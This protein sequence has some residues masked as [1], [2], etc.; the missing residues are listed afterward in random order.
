MCY[1][2]VHSKQQ[3]SLFSST[4]R[5]LTMSDQIMRTKTLLFSAAVLLS[6]AACSQGGNSTD[7]PHAGKTEDWFRAHPQALQQEMAW[8]STHSGLPMTGTC[9]V[10]LKVSDEQ[11]PM[12]SAGHMTM[13]APIDN[14]GK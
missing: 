5:E 9:L 12:P 10:A 3:A 7:G 1:T 6:M 8:C 13:G 14:Y 4:N 2:E 11:H